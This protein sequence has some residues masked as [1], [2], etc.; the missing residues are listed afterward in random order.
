MG[1]F[2]QNIYLKLDNDKNIVEK[3]DLKIKKNKVD[4]KVESGL[5]AKIGAEVLFGGE[6][7]PY[8][9]KVFGKNAEALLFRNSKDYDSISFNFSTG[10]YS[11]TL[12]ELDGAKAKYCINGTASCELFSMERLASYFNS[13]VS[14]DD[15]LKELQQSVRDAFVADA[16]MSIG[17]YINSDIKTSDA[18]QE[19]EKIRNDIVNSNGAAIQK[20]RQMGLDLSPS[21][22]IFKITPVTDTEE[23]VEKVNSKLQQNAIDRLDEVKAD[24]ERAQRL[25]EKEMDQTHE[26]NVIRAQNTSIT[27]TK[28][29]GNQEEKAEKAEETE[30][31][32]CKYCGAKVSKTAKFCPKCG[33]NIEEV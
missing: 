7:Y 13:N 10:E 16:K 15:I 14:M 18:Y 8:P 4:I 12:D 22:I 11:L 3:K 32:F 9:R 25:E 20:I 28:I 29:E 2:K 24:K 19:F 30:T 21:G 33:R 6:T 17:K 27:E 31:K 23:L 26:V 1:L 5:T